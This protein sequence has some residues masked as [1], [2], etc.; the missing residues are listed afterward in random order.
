MGQ[1]AVLLVDAKTRAGKAHNLSIEACWIS[2]SNKGGG[3]LNG[4]V[5]KIKVDIVVLSVVTYLL[6]ETSQQIDIVNN[7]GHTSSLS[8]VYFR[9]TRCRCP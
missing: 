4:V 9:K 8:P 2:Y 7:I 1:A 5:S 3:W 6:Y